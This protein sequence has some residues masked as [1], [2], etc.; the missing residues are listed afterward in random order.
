MSLCHAD[1][2]SHVT[3][4]DMAT[5]WYNGAPLKG[6]EHIQ[7]INRSISFTDGMVQTKRPTNQIKTHGI[8]TTRG[9]V[10]AVVVC[11]GP[12]YF[13]R[14]LSPSHFWCF[15]SFLRCLLESVG[16]PSGFPSGVS[17]LG[18]PSPGVLRGATSSTLR[19]SKLVFEDSSDIGARRGC[20]DGGRPLAPGRGE[21]RRTA[22]GCSSAT[23]IKVHLRWFQ[24]I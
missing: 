9:R 21:E 14:S 11:G 10:S 17:P 3:I 22:R 13:L 8:K 2:F 23:R 16:F 12:T 15:R 18:D 7:T 1:N 19:S 20:F 4:M 24:L 6:L 5:W